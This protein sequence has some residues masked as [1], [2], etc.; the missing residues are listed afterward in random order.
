MRKIYDYKDIRRLED[1]SFKSILRNGL[2]VTATSEL[3]LAMTSYYPEYEVRDIHSFIEKI[4]PE[5]EGNIKDIKN[6]VMLRNVIEDYVNDNEIDQASAT[7]LRRNAGDMWNAIKLLIEADIYPEDI[8]VLNSAP[9]RHFKGIWT[10][11]EVDNEQ[12]MSFRAAFSFELSQSENVIRKI[13]GAGILKKDLFLFGF[14]FI[15]PIQDRIFD[16]LEKSGYNLFFLNCHDENYEYATAIWKKTF[17]SYYEEEDVKNIQQGYPL[18]N[19]FGDALLRRENDIPIEIV[20]HYTELDFAEMVKAAIERGES[21][22]SPDAKRCEKILKEYFPEYYNR[23]HLLSYPVGQYI[24]YLHMM[25]NTF[26]NHIDLDYQ[27]VYKC[28]ASGWLTVDKENGRDYLYEVKILEPYFKGCHSK[29]DWISRLK[30][31]VDAKNSISSFNNRKHGNERWHKLL[32]NPFN[33]VGIYTISKETINIVV[34]MIEKL[35][36]DAEYLFDKGDRTDLYEHF[37]RITKIIQTHIDKEELL[38]EEVEITSELLNQLND[39]TTIGIVCPMSGVRDAIVMMLGDYFDEYES[40]EEET[41]NRDRMVLP[42]SMVEAAMLNNYG[43]KIHLVLADEFSLPGQPKK[44]PW[45][46]TNEMID[47]LYIQERE[48]T[49]RYVEDMRAVINNRPLSYRYLFFS[50]IGT[51]NMENRPIL[52]IEWVCNRDKTEIDASPYIQLLGADDCVK[53]VIGNRCD[54]EKIVKRSIPEETNPSITIPNNEVPEEVR[55]DYLLCEKRYA[56]SYLLNELPRFTSEFHYSFE[57]SKLISA[58]TIISGSPKNVVAERISELFPFLRHIEL[59]QSA[60]FASSQG[61]LEP[62]IFDDIEYP[63]QRLSLHYLYDELIK[64]AKKRDDRFLT[65]GTVNK[66]LFVN[67]CIYCPYSDVC[68]DRHKEEVV[69]YEQ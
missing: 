43:Q 20:K 67:S 63:Y 26:S 5:W 49:K 68:L 30:Q 9:L 59:R 66:T 34:K 60:D 12:I 23:K 27:Y 11:L 58:F 52:S 18:V 37:Q 51:S 16:V 42:L 14:Y 32:G 65:D 40:Q 13:E 61:K 46:L 33:N 29:E 1:T 57:L 47:G 10:K 25:W 31:L 62:Y 44:L 17:H 19:Y 7:Y 2:I 48:H 50:F 21:V 36:E 64:E 55:M 35:I 41:S 38:Q 3:A 56:Y 22:Y 45:P 53:D 24:N 39:E 4:I 8:D 54:Y 28:F 69:K 15:T 6:Y